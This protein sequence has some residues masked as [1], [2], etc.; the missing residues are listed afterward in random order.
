VGGA[1]SV[2]GA[3]GASGSTGSGRGG[4]GGTQ[5]SG[6]AAGTAGSGGGAGSSV[7]GRG[8]SSTGGTTGAGGAAAGT[9]G[10]GG[11]G[12]GATTPGRIEV[13]ALCQGT[14]GMQ[15]IRVTFRILNPESVTKQLSDIKVRYYFTPT[16]QM[17]PNVIFDYTQKIPKEMITST[18]TASYVEVGFMSGTGTLAAFDNVTGTD[19]IQ[20][21]LQ[22][23]ST[24]TWN[25][26]QD[27]DYSYKS[28]A[29]V[30]NT[31]AYVDRTTMPG[32]YQ[33]Q[34]AWG[35]EPSP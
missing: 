20:L 18:A 11:A 2:G 24:P 26:S 35:A 30:T 29:G 17:A 14:N 28:C 15:D 34:L 13:Q 31:S 7:G 27:D 10:A 32:Y 23:T 9:T 25:M 8:G 16:A 12:G 4:A 19:Q 6:G 1:T 22:N 5:G 33:G 3:S 21:H